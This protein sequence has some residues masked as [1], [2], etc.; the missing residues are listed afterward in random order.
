MIDG[1]ECF[2][3][4]D[5]KARVGSGYTEP[6]GQALQHQRQPSSLRSGAS[7]QDRKEDA[8][9]ERVLTIS[10]LTAEALRYAGAMLYIPGIVLMRWAAFG[11]KRNS[12]AVRGS[13]SLLKLANFQSPRLL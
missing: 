1:N 10:C 4:P 6:S 11:D 9:M 8:F 12:S 2:Y 13:R 3:Q 7:I 5:V